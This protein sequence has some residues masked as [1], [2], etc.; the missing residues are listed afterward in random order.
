MMWSTSHEHVTKKKSKSPTGIEPMTFR[1]PVGGGDALTTELS[2]FKVAQWLEPPPP[3]DRCTEG[4]GFNIVPVGDFDF[5]LVPCSWHIDHIISH[6]FS[7][8]KLL[9]TIFLFTGII[10]IQSASFR[11]IAPFVLPWCLHPFKSL[12]LKPRS[13][14]VTTRNPRIG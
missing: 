10:Q 9:T 3:S 2:G 5:F 8:V 7:E 14:S 13:L 11:L 12:F 6:F 4:R 1:T